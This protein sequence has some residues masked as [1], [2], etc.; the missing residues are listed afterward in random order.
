MLK[1]DSVMRTQIIA[2][3]CLIIAA[4][5]AVAKAHLEPVCFSGAAP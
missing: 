1:G 2:T 5:F 3:L 4:C